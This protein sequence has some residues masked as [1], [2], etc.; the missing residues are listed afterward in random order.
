MRNLAG[1]GDFEGMALSGRMSFGLIPHNALSFRVT[2]S[3][4]NWTHHTD[5]LFDEL[6]AKIGNSTTIEEAKAASTDADMY[7]ISQHWGVYT[8]VTPS[9]MVFQPYLKG[10]DGEYWAPASMNSFFPTRI[11]IDQEMKESM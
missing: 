1:S 7:L 2:T 10:Y 8:L 9:V 3:P 5:T 11:W 6:V 4:N